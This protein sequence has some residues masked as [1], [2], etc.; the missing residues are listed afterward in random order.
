MVVFV[1]EVV[2]II[3]IIMGRI[4]DQKAPSFNFV[5]SDFKFIRTALPILQLIFLWCC[6]GYIHIHTL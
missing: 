5:L 1:I 6:I 2:M 4:V 3:I